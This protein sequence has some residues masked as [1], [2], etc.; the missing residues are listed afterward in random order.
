MGA[1]K[2]RN[3][4][5]EKIV[6][7]IAHRLGY[8]FRL[9]R[10]DLPGKP[11]LAFPG[12]RAVIFVHGC[13]WHGHDCKRGARPKANADFWASKLTRNIARDLD[14]SRR[15]SE[16]GWRQL[17]LWECELKEEAALA[18]RLKDFLA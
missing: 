12:R 7:R 4:G 1:V 18:A 9:H 6:R 2:G 3:T 13:F 10:A 15:L 14:Q 11:D 16:G 8:R 5:P 17:V